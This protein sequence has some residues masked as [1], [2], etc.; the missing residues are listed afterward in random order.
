MELPIFPAGTTIIN[1]SL[2]FHCDLQENIVYFYGHLPV[3]QHAKDDIRTH[4]LIM[5]QLYIN[6]TAKQTELAKAFG[7]NVIVIKRA[8]ALYRDKGVSGFFEEKKSGGP[9]ILVPGVLEIIQV[10]LNEGIEV[11]DIAEELKIKLDTIKKAIQDGR[12][13]KSSQQCNDMRTKSK[14]SIKDANASLGMGA[15]DSLGRTAARFGLVQGVKPEFVNCLDVPQ[16]GVLLA[17]PALLAN[18]LLD[19]TKDIFKMKEAFYSIFSLFICM[20]FMALARIK[21]IEGMRHVA[22]GE[23]GKLLGLDRSPEPRC[24]RNKI[25]ELSKEN[26]PQK[27]SV[28]LGADWLKGTPEEAGVLYVDG[29]VRVYHGSQT[30][31]PR[32]YVTRQKLCLRATTDYWVNT[33]SGNPVFFITKTVD[34]GLIHVLEHDVIPRLL[35]DVPGQPSQKELDEDKWLSRFTIVFDREGYSPGL[36]KRLWDKRIAVQT[37][38]KGTHE[39]WLKEEFNQHDIQLPGS[40]I[41]QYSLAERGTYVGGCLWMREIRKLKSSTRGG[42]QCSMI[43]TNFKNNLVVISTGIFSRW[44]QENYFKYMRENFSLDR[45][46]DYETEPV[47]GDTKIINPSYRKLDSE[48]KKNNSLLCKRKAKF[49]SIL[50]EGDIDQ[51]KVEKHVEE[52]GVLLAEIQSLE[53]KLELLKKERKKEKK[54]ITVEELQ[55]QDQFEQLSQSG[56]HLI[57]TVKM[58]AYRA[59]TAMSN[60]LMSI[61]PD[62]DKNA[63]R[64]LLR[65]IYNNT[66]DLVVDETNKILRVR[67]HHLATR[68]HDNALRKICEELTVTETEFPESG[69]KM[70]YEMIDSNLV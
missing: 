63:T 27:W 47:Q 43:S 24:M 3:F 32:H 23:W 7:I 18:G 37:Y 39:E 51:E 57:D 33:A 58:I 14:R 46:I 8:A 29:H 40:E 59:E 61:V 53:T 4:R 1:R 22:P 2:A 36:F 17:L 70:V 21:S 9:R 5:A 26:Q 49:G 52:K 31:L 20:A 28:K 45:L 55:E 66:V 42:N 56:K 44:S 41:V 10:K 54:H 60:L 62:F 11:S 64:V 19:H 65:E 38:Y 30:Q 34:P 48:I 25:K 6:G 12:L 68:G 35:Q 13:K 15:T 50:L 67:M 16:G 69:L